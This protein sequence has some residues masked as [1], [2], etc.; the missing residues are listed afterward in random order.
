[1]AKLKWRNILI[2]ILAALV[3]VGAG[4]SKKPKEPAP[5]PSQGKQ[6]SKKLK[7]LQTS[8][9]SLQK[10]FESIYLM[11]VAPAPTPPKEE[12]KDETEDQKGTGG[13]G[14]KG[15]KQGGKDSGGGGGGGGEK[16]SGG[17]DSGKGGDMMAFQIMAQGSESSG[18]KKP[19][20]SKMEQLVTQVHESWNA[21]Q[22][23]AAKAGAGSG[24]IEDLSRK[25]DEVTIAITGQDA[26]KGLLW[27]NEAYFKMIF[28]EK[29]FKTEAPPE[30]K[31]VM[32]LLRRAAYTAL[33]GDEEPALVS[34]EQ[35]QRVFKDVKPQLKDREALQQ[36]EFALGDLKGAIK[37]KDPNLIKIRLRICAENVQEVLKKPQKK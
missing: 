15:N 16:K 13:E 14:Q 7:E 20:W 11:E 32:Y 5:K 26:Y 35:A 9:D 22:P 4:C 31:E 24:K 30:L 36:V 10:E 23:E 3:S 25:L 18:G 19:D 2:I 6:E 28:F 34:V 17:G 33:K 37:A 29:L 12:K 27:V 21:F 1:M 8:I